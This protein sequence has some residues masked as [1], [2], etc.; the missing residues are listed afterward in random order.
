[1]V[2]S[3]VY[4][5]KCVLIGKNFKVSLLGKKLQVNLPQ[6]KDFG[7]VIGPQKYLH[8]LKSSRENHND[9]AYE[10]FIFLRAFADL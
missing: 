8:V 4:P 10:L 5:F 6:N 7:I 2:N 9:P 3:K 1:M